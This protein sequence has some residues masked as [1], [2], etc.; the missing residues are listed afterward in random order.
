[1]SIKII[2]SCRRRNSQI[3]KLHVSLKLVVS[4]TKELQHIYL[5]VQKVCQKP[6]FFPIRKQN[7][8]KLLLFVLFELHTILYIAQYKL[9]LQSSDFVAAAA[10]F[11]VSLTAVRI[12]TSFQTKFSCRSQL[13]SAYSKGYNTCFYLGLLF[14]YDANFFFYIFSGC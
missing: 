3:W 8:F 4:V 6:C 13:N 9:S 2:R 11:F 10:K 5:Q 12:S 7:I 1:M 14:S